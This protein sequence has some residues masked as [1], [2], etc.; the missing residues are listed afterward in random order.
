[1]PHIGRHLARLQSLESYSSRSLTFLLP[2]IGYR[3]LSNQSL[4][5]H[6]HMHKH[7]YYITKNSSPLQC[8]CMRVICMRVIACVLFA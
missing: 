1:M 6:A 7:N 8:Y 2:R 4:K 5:K 3:K